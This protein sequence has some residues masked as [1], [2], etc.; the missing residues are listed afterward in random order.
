VIQLHVIRE[1]GL[2][3]AGPDPK[4]LIDPVAPEELRRAT[5]GVLLEWWAPMLQSPVRL[6]SREYQ[7]YAV[8]TICRALYT[9]E[10]GAV[11]P[12]DVAARWAQTVLDD[13]WQAVIERALAWPHGPQP[14]ELDQVLAL[15]RHTLDRALSLGESAT[16]RWG[17]ISTRT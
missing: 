1:L 6:R 14:D 12:K 16:R 2:V 13:R 3:L 11:V 17:R 15:I 10:H 8:L 9:L 7:A 5:H 4:T